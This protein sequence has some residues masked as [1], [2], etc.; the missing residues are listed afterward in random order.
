MVHVG[1][2]VNRAGCFENPGVKIL[3]MKSEEGGYDSEEERGGRRG[4]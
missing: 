2:A 4:W 3:K 1:V